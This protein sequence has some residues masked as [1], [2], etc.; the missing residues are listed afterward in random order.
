MRR[1]KLFV[2]PAVMMLG[3]CVAQAAFDLATLPVRAVS[4][5]VDLATTS[6]SESD[7]KRGRALREREERLGKL[8]RAYQRQ[9]EECEDG[10]RRACDAARESYAEMQTL[11]PT[12]PREPDPNR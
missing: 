11:I 4:K 7:E 5:G 3:G 9:M 10:S 12:L 2:L 1:T 8:E 6:Q